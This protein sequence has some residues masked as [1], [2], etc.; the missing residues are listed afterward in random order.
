VKEVESV[1]EE[2]TAAQAAA[3]AAGIPAL[4]AADNLEDYAVAVALALRR[5]GAP[6]F[7]PVL[8]SRQSRLPDLP[9]PSQPLH[10]QVAGGGLLAGRDWRSFQVL[11]HRW[12]APRD[13]VP[14][15][16]W[17]LTASWPSSDPPEQLGEAVDGCL[18]ELRETPPAERPAA[19]A[20]ALGLPPPAGVVAGLGRC[21]PLLP[22][23]LHASL[24]GKPFVWLEDASELLE[25][26]RSP[27]E[28]LTIST[29]LADLGLDL[30]NELVRARSFRVPL[31]RV[32]ALEFQARPLSFFAARTTEIL[33]R[34]AVKHE[35]YRR[36]PL[37][38]SAW[39]FTAETRDH[40]TDPE[41]TL[42]THEQATAA[43]VEM[44]QDP[45]LLAVWG[46]SREDLLH[47]GPDAICGLSA[48]VPVA[49][50]PGPFPACVHDGHCIK[51]GELLRANRLPAKVLLLGGCNLMRLGGRGGFAPEFTIAFSAQEGACAVVVAS[52]RTRFGLHQDQILMHQLMKGGMP[53]GE[54]VRVTNNALPFLGPESPDFLV[55]GEG[56]WRPFGPGDG[57]AHVEVSADG[58]GWLVDCSDVDAHYVEA[59]IPKLEGEPHV[60]PLEGPFEEAFHAISPE[61]DGGARVILFGWGRLR[62]DRL[63]FR[64]TT[65]PP[66]R[67]EGEALT[68]AL[69]NHVYD[70]LFASYL[71]RFENQ[72]QELHSLGAHIARHL[73]EAAYRPSEHA[74]VSAKAAEAAALLGRLDESLCRYLL[75]KVGRG[76]FVWMEQCTE[77]DG[78]FHV[79]EHLEPVPCPYCGSPVARKVLRHRFEPAAAREFALCQ[80]C[81]NVWDVPLGG[82]NPLLEGPDHL[83]RGGVHSQTVLVANPD[84]RPRRG[85]LGFRV[86]QAE[87]HGVVVEPAATEVTL[88]PGGT[89]RVEFTVRLGR[90]MPA[91]LEYERGFWVG[92][93]SVSVFQ[94]NVWIEPEKGEGQA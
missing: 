48:E 13:M 17:Y 84:D 35:L 5:R 55:L 40:P 42:L 1:L 63:R 69:R 77:V 26:A 31:P 11:W 29:P 7:L 58:E 75:D 12:L 81:G 73:T 15:M 39:L 56:D 67:A 66:A 92:E 4:L 19:V 47:L 91:H 16:R 46:H 49:G 70:R 85:W 30:L 52:R 94:R 57:R 65:E 44:L 21:E 76:A 14:P 20:Q 71:P 59:R 61:P 60:Q 87:K 88:E 38:S 36:Q 68:A 23:M 24:A 86:Y 74:R 27:I 32:A 82:I 37:G 54:A 41:V 78:S 28:W 9:F 6:A 45:D 89:A 50:S 25:L 43:H 79:A 3:P 64:V 53:L 93:L 62:A 22:A 51:N 83:A 2:P 8:A 10:E 34:L 33:S 80:S 18:Q 90:G 72:R